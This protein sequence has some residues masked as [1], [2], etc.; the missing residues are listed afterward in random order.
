MG[1][2]S[3]SVILTEWFWISSV[4]HLLEFRV[5]GQ[6]SGTDDLTLVRIWTLGLF[7]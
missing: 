4:S 5:R 7:L 3:M 1:P 2:I 6:L